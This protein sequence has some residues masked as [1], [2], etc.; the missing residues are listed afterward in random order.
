M[1]VNSDRLKIFENLDEKIK[2]DEEITD[3]ELEVKL[4]KTDETGKI[5]TEF[6]DETNSSEPLQIIGEKRKNSEKSNM[7]IENKK[8]KEEFAVYEELDHK[9]EQIKQEPQE[10]TEIDFDD[11]ENQVLYNKP[12]VA[13][14]ELSVSN[15][16][17]NTL[18]TT[19]FVSQRTKRQKFGDFKKQVPLRGQ[20]GHF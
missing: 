7:E 10:I 6:F 12:W 16:Q 4:E 15:E 9:Y 3:L 20:K 8:I 13:F 17:Y 18:Y 1:E 2:F 19:S 11:S 14:S 5:K